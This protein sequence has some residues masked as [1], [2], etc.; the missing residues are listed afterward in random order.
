LK[1][2]GYIHRQ[3]RPID[4]TLLFWGWSITKLGLCVKGKSITIYGGLGLSYAKKVCACPPPARNASQR[5]AGG[6][7]SPVCLARPWQAVRPRRGL[8]LRFQPVGLTGRRVE[9]TPRRAGGKDGV[10]GEACL[11]NNAPWWKLYLFSLNFDRL[12]HRIPCQ[13]LNKNIIH[14]FYL[15]L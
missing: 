5:E 2:R 3:A 4:K 10:A 15:W 14:Q 7:L 12:L 6:S 8:R 1:S 13:F 9:P 11:F